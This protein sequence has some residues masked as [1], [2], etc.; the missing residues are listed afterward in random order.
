M[1]SKEPGAGT[2]EV[3]APSSGSSVPASSPDSVP[4]SGPGRFTTAGGGSGTVGRSSRLLRYEVVVEDGLKQS[5]ADVAKQAEGVLAD[6]RG[7]TADGESAFRR[8]TGGTPDFVVRLATPGTVDK[9][10]THHGTCRALT[11]HPHRRR[12]ASGGLP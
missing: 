3:G 11:G 1:P 6:P 8:V 12:S 4:S 9:G 10:P 2:S 7:W 5:A